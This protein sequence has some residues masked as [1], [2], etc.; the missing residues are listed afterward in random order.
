MSSPARVRSIGS[1]RQAGRL[2]VCMEI[3]KSCLSLFKCFGRT[4]KNSSETGPVHFVGRM[5]RSIEAKSSSKYK[6]PLSV[7]AVNLTE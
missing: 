5:T 3:K 4:V 7:F 2:G 6:I 1:S